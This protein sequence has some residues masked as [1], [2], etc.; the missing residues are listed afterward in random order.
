MTS[1]HFIVYALCLSQ[2]TMVYVWVKDKFY[3]KPKQKSIS[4]DE[5]RRIITNY[6]EEALGYFRL[7]LNSLEEHYRIIAAN[8]LEKFI[9]SKYQEHW[10]KQF[11]TN[12]PDNKNG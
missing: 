7:S 5:F 9:A 12:K 3:N 2:L 10:E 6:K 4:P 8:N 1:L 11:F